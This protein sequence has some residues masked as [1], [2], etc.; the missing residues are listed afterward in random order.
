MLP[1]MVIGRGAIKYRLPDW[2]YDYLLEVNRCNKPIS[3]PRSGVIEVR[4]PVSGNFSS[5]REPARRDEVAAQ[6]YVVKSLQSWHS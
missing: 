5:G 3:V 4:S 6:L 1:R 2:S